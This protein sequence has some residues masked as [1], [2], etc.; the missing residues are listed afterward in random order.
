MEALI[1][2]NIIVTWL[3][4]GIVCLVLEAMAITGAGFLFVCL[5]AITIGG[6][7]NLGILEQSSY[8]EQL[9]LFLAFVLIWAAILWIPLKNFSFKNKSK[10]FNNIVGDLVE[11]QS[12]I[13]TKNKIGKVKWSGTIIQA[14]LDFD[15]KVESVEKGAGVY[16]KFID[17]NVVTV[18][19]DKDFVKK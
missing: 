11:V 10:G 15:D 4:F 12:G 19:T 9:S 18:A 2:N 13:L 3:T 8:A 14:R 6:L 1:A 5:S 16:I 17:G 7:L